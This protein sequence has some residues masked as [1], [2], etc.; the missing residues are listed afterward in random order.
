MFA[1]SI[2]MQTTCPDRVPA[3]ATVVHSSGPE[4]GL[5]DGVKFIK[6]RLKDSPGE[7]A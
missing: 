7:I 5:P 1:R 2:T 4:G 3:D 6:Q